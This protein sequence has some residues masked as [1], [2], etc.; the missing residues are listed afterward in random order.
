MLSLAKPR[1]VSLR[2]CRDTGKMG[3]VAR[4]ADNFAFFVVVPLTASN[5]KMDFT[6][7]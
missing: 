5:A 7:L 1:P 2:A 3:I 4:L 6:F